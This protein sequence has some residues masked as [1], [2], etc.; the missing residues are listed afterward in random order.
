MLGIARTNAIASQHVAY[1]G[2]AVPHTLIV[3][4]RAE[5]G[6][7]RCL[8]DATGYL[9]GKQRFQAKTNL[10]ANFPLIWRNEDHHAVIDI[11]STNSHRI[12]TL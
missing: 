11:G 10:D 7:D 5:L 1:G 9:V 8:N 4:A 6:H 2:Y 12:P 3:I